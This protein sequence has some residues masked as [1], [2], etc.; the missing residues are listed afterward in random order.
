MH[1][2]K[3]RSLFHV[4]SF[5]S[6]SSQTSFLVLVSCSQ[7][8]CLFSERRELQTHSLSLSLSL[9]LNMFCLCEWEEGSGK[10]ERMNLSW[11]PTYKQLTLTHSLYTFRSPLGS[12]SFFLF[13][14]LNS[15]LSLPVFSLSLS[16]LH[17]S[18]SCPSLFQLFLS[19]SLS[20][21]HNC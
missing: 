6:S 18:S 12:S 11:K 2:S 17:T 19:S 5:S 16:L 10:R 1:C 15:F 8:L 9:F 7:S 4:S 3:F 13:F 20:L 14:S 21:L